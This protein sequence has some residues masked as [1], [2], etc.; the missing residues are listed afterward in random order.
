MTTIA[1]EALKIP[2]F[3]RRDFLVAWSYR[4]S[5]VSDLVGLAGQ[6]LVFYFVSQIVDPSKLPTFQGTQVTYLEFATVGLVL[7]G[8]IHFGMQNVAAAMRNEQLMGTL[9]SLLV[10]PTAPYTV[11]LGSVA[12]V[13]LYIPIR[14]ALL[15]AVLALSF[16]L[17]FQASGILPALGLLVV[18]M[19]FVWGLGVASAA[20][21][22]TFRRGSGLV[23]LGTL[24]LAFVSGLYF[25]IELLPGWLTAV[26]EQNPIA[27]A[28]DGMRDALLGGAGWSEIGPSIL[29][30]APMALATLVLGLYAFRL[31]LSRERRKGTVGLY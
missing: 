18:F 10:T 26:A 14:I 31:A 25:P 1:S 5:F 2:A 16:G 21:I 23:G 19:P 9:E 24:V 3:V 15:V 30:L 27:I 8:F 13:F 12:F 7:G 22:V 29:V 17:D 6:A 20:V 28:V 4:M 11:Q